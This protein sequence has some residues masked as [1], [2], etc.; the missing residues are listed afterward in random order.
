M[1]FT[2]YAVRRSD[3]GGI[4]IFGV[5]EQ[6]V[7][8]EFRVHIG[9]EDIP[10][11]VKVAASWPVLRMFARK[12]FVAI[13]A[14]WRRR[15][16]QVP[17]GLEDRVKAAHSRVMERPRPNRV[18]RDAPAPQSAPA[19]TTTG[20]VGEP[21]ASVEGAAGASGDGSSHAAT[22]RIAS[23][24]GGSLQSLPEDTD[25]LRPASKERRVV[26]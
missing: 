10:G 17:E 9:A 6:P 11:I 23:L 26:L 12:P 22:P 25:S 3:D 8:W 1:D 7:S 21:V 15:H 20:P 16:F 13:G 2:H 5:T 14:A 24:A 19:G 18:V 4:E